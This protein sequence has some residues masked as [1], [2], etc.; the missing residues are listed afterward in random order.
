MSKE[1][2]IPLLT[3]DSYMDPSDLL[4]KSLDLSKCVLMCQFQ[5]R[6]LPLPHYTSCSTRHTSLIVFEKFQLAVVLFKK[7]WRIWRKQIEFG[8]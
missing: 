7:S 4:R 5:S 1:D 6:S 8:I 2:F 3:V